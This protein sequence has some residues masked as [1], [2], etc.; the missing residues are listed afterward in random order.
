MGWADLLF[1]MGI[2]YD[3]EEALELADQLMAFINEKAHDMSAK[4]AEERGPFP[5]W[6]RSIYKNDRPLRNSTVTTI[7][8]TGTISIIAGCSSGI[9][10]VFAFSFGRRIL[11]EAFIPEVYDY[12]IEMAH[13]EGFYSDKMMEEVSKEGSIQSIPYIPDVIKRVF[14]TAHDIP[15]E[16]HVRTQAAFQKYTDNAVSK[17][18]NFSSNT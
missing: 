16:W 13:R 10:P 9:E 14:V 1:E 15:A 5:N 11:D 8:P 6:E 18:I 2:P 4:L 17:T 7:A 3:G 12:F